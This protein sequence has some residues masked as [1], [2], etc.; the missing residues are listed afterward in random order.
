MFW[1]P[2]FAV[3]YIAQ[4]IWYNLLCNHEFSKWIHQVAVSAAFLFFIFF[5]P[6]I[7]CLLSFR[8]EY[9]KLFDFV[10]AKKLNIKN[11]GF[12]EVTL[13]FSFSLSPVLRHFTSH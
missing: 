11:R 6:H 4:D 5:H 13:F 9:G 2:D 10:N 8:E 12:K 1:Q 3:N 7:L